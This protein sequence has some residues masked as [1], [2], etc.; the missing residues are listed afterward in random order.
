MKWQLQPPERKKIDNSVNVE[1]TTKA[2]NM[3][4]PEI[5]GTVEIRTKEY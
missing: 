3:I 2:S 1:G 4:W 5:F